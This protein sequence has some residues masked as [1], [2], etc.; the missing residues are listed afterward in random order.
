MW[1]AKINRILHFYANLM[2]MNLS[3]DPK[4]R[5]ALY[6]DECPPPLGLKRSFRAKK[7]GAALLPF[8]VFKRVLRAVLLEDGAGV[9]EDVKGEVKWLSDSSSESSEALIKAAARTFEF[10]WLVH[11]D[12][13][14][15]AVKFNKPVDPAVKVCCFN[16]WLTRHFLPVGL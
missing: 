15:K 4:S 2:E 7:E 12:C 3:S 11:V 8:V 1:G 16:E 6:L 5:R 10:P 9:Q 14:V 13:L